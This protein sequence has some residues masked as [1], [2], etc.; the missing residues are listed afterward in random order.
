MPLAAIVRPRVAAAKVHVR[1]VKA[2]APIGSA[3]R[4]VSTADATNVR[5]H[6]A[7][8]CAGA[9]SHHI[10]DGTAGENLNQVG[11]R[12][13]VVP[14]SWQLTCPNKQLERATMLD[15]RRVSTAA[16][17]EDKDLRHA[18]GALARG[19]ASV[20]VK[21]RAL[22][23]CSGN[24]AQ[25][26][27]VAACLDGNAILM[28]VVKRTWDRPSR[29][30]TDELVLSK[31]GSRQ[32]H[33]HATAVNACWIRA[34]TLFP[35]RVGCTV[36]K[37]HG[38]VECLCLSCTHV[39]LHSKVVLVP[40]VR[41]RQ[42]C[43]PSD[44][45]WIIWA[46]QHRRVNQ[47]D[48]ML[49]GVIE[50]AKPCVLGAVEDELHIH[51]RVGGCRRRDHLCGCSVALHCHHRRLHPAYL[52]NQPLGQAASIHCNLCA[53]VSRTNRRR[54]TFEP[55]CTGISQLVCELLRSLVSAAQLVERRA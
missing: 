46:Q 37:E 5:T 28:A 47:V 50:H 42:V 48:R 34:V 23:R 35:L 30:L 13:I 2:L 49:C 4:A 24:A 18:K 41:A 15:P 17:G 10:F 8:D 3:A 20:P 43:S 9:I 7:S 11:Q 26:R 39:H 36:E 12:L 44:Y 21:A 33:L 25:S 31:R 16:D 27:A 32:V 53:A 54:E 45:R 38:E 22:D 14:A 52:D 40:R 51:E 55:N 19:V 29:R 1:D 6:T